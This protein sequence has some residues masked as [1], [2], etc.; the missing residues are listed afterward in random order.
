[1]EFID[2]GGYMIALGMVFGML[3]NLILHIILRKEKDRIA[4][5]IIYNAPEKS[6]V[7]LGRLIF[8]NMS[9]VFSSTVIYTWLGLLLAK[10]FNRSTLKDARVWHQ[11]IK[12]SY[13]KW[14]YLVYVMQFGFNFFFAGAIIFFIANALKS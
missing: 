7:V 10:V 3:P 2:I 4:W 12:E 9:W 6:K 13:G 14:R 5:H 11:S 8:W 1:M